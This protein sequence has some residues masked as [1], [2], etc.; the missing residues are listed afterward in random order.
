MTE[1]LDSTAQ[2]IRK[3]PDELATFITNVP[4][5]TFELIKNTSR[6]VLD[7]ICFVVY[8]IPNLLTI[9]FF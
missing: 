3:L 1:P 7:C 2:E 9:F 4:V 5:E 8:W 6:I